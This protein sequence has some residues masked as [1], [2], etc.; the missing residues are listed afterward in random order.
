MP[1]PLYREGCRALRETDTMD[2]FVDSS[3]YFMRYIDAHNDKEMVSGPLARQWLP[4]DVYIGGIEH[5]MC[6]VTIM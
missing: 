4:V 3:W 2:T 5:G 1:H 6:H